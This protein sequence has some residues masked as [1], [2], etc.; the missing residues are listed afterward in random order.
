MPDGGQQGDT[1]SVTHD[2]RSYA[3]SVPA[4]KAPGET[5]NVSI[6]AA[7]T[8]EDLNPSGKSWTVDQGLQQ[9]ERERAAHALLTQQFTDL[10]KTLDEAKVRASPHAEDAIYDTE[11]PPM[12]LEENHSLGMRLMQAEQEHGLMSTELEQVTHCSL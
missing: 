8:D 4:D 2:G 7:S 1:V 6:P 9:I 3:V 12:N 5:F 10:Q 11:N